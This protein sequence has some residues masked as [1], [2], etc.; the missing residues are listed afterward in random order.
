MTA[1]SKPL[2]QLVWELVLYYFKVFKKN[3]N[4]FIDEKGRELLQ[5]I[6]TNDELSKYQ[7]KALSMGN[8]HN[9]LEIYFRNFLAYMK[10]FKNSHNIK[11]SSSNKEFIDHF[12]SNYSKLESCVLLSD[13]FRYKI[14]I[15]AFRITF[16]D[17]V[18]EI[19][20][21]SNHKIKKIYNDPQPYDIPKFKKKPRYWEPFEERE[22]SIQEA[23]TSFEISFC[24]IKRISSMTPY[25]N[26]IPHYPIDS[27]DEH[28]E[29]NE[30]VF[31]IYDFFSCYTEH[32]DFPPFTF[33]YQ[34]FVE[35]PPFSQRPTN[36]SP[37]IIRGFLRYQFHYPKGFLYLKDSDILV[38]WKEKWKLKYNDFYNNFYKI[39]A[40]PKPKRLLRYTIS[41]L[42][43]EFN[44]PYIPMRIFY[45]VSILEGFLYKKNLC[46]R[47]IK[48]ININ[49]KALNKPTFHD[50]TKSIPIAKIFSSVSNDQKIRWDKYFQTQYKNESE[51]SINLEKFIISTF[52]FRNN[53]A[54]PEKQINFDFEP[55]H[56]FKNEPI[57]IQENHFSR[58]ILEIFPIFLKFLLKIFLV[59]NCTCNND[60][61]D[62]I[63]NLFP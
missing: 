15:P 31:S 46:K 36:T 32:F 45:L 30:K 2:K 60:W 62:Y 29:I 20:L 47:I 7:W 22:S 44:I 26:F 33:G 59:K 56:L 14:L 8:E 13:Y 28:N 4:I 23:D 42:R 11:D 40:D 57:D 55:K 39:R 52:K 1:E 37:D 54:H 18:D 49:R 53:I 41:V 5:D 25:D 61:Y 10:N 35:L 43:T 19:I 48:K 50:G 38:Y 3:F 27:W 16:P 12:E 21:D 9:L 51:H 24:K 58:F 63:D 17:N 6:N 34:F